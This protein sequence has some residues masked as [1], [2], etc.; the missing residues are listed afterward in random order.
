MP[1]MQSVPFRSPWNPI[2]PPGPVPPQQNNWRLS[3]ADVSSI[4]GTAS[5]SGVDTA[6]TAAAIAAAAA[7]SSA[8]S[9][10][11]GTSVP[12]AGVPGGS[13]VV[14]GVQ[15]PG[16]LRSDGRLTPSLD[17]AVLDH[18]FGWNAA[19]QVMFQR[20][21]AAQQIIARIRRKKPKDPALMPAA[22][23]RINPSGTLLISPG[24][25][26]GIY[27]VLTYRVPP[28]YY[29]FINYASNEYTG[30]GFAEA[31]GAL[32][33]EIQVQG[34]FYPNYG[35]I[36]YTL[37]SRLNGWWNIAG[38]LPLLG[39]QYITYLVRYDTT[40]GVAT[41]GYVICGLQGWISPL[42]ETAREN[43]GPS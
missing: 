23:T 30:G 40:V 12:V 21:Q 26:S 22:G 24:L 27:A 42:G 36:P 34:W 4:Y 37:G 17:Q 9:V 15:I 16:A 1:L 25:A 14:A 41:G 8:S 13:A 43:G 28:G 39:N 29:G 31:A 33:W 19:S 20:F 6:G 3:P 7:T 11:P 35:T 32:I 2:N 5:D 18:D 10:V 38:G